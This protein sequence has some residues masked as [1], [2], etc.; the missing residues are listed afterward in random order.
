[1][2]RRIVCM[3]EETTECLYRMGEEDRIVGISAFTV[4]PARA[5]DE[6]PTPK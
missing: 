1:M 2:S 3:T 5:K 6:K 4:R